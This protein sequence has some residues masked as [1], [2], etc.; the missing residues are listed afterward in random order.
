M[1]SE[2]LRE[3]SVLE[4]IDDATSGWV[5]LWE[6]RVEVQRAQKE[7]LNNIKEAKDFNSM[8]QNT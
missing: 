6:K 5:L 1:I 8:G 7:T 4:D 3:V 2:I